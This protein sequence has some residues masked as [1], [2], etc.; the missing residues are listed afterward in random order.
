MNRNDFYKKMDDICPNSLAE[1]WD[2]CGIQINCEKKE[3]NTVLVALEVTGEVVNEAI[4]KE[5]DII[6]THH[7]LF[8]DKFN[9]LDM[10]DIIGNYAVKLIKNGIS[11]YSCH[12]SFDIMNGGN[13]DYIGKLLEIRN[14][15]PFQ[16]TENSFCRK[17]KLNHTLSFQDTIK[18]VSEKLQID[19]KF[20]H[21]IGDLLKP[22]SNVGWCTGGGAGFIGD[23]IL[24]NCDLFIT[25]DLKYHDGQNAK[26]NG[27]CIIDAG[28][29]GTEKIFV[30][31]M[32]DYLT[33]YTSC[34]ILR[35]EIDIN[36]FVC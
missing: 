30:D 9:K 15:K 33:K 25:G 5:A 4:E 7:P 22:I 19:T 31:N 14:I 28:H 20:I 32:A 36:P 8:F 27:I 24:E 29:Y 12:T 1:E 11:V 23:A 26:E 6:V 3:I 18:Y 17:G 34:K 16:F 35:S 10:K 21:G 2:N 13:N